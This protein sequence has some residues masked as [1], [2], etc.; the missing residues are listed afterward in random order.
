MALGIY[1]A[2]PR[3]AP[4]PCS[5]DTNTWAFQGALDAHHRRSD[6]ARC[7]VLG[8][9]RLLI[10]LSEGVHDGLDRHWGGCA[11]VG[12]HNQTEEFLADTFCSKG[13]RAFV[14][15]VKGI[16]VDDGPIS[17]LPCFRMG[18]AVSI[19]DIRVI[20]SAVECNAVASRLRDMIAP[21]LIHL[22]GIALA[23]AMHAIA[24]GREQLQFVLRRQHG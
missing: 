16:C 17:G 22:L 24:L 12:R 19:S 8:H 4:A 9:Q 10:N 3:A 2:K 1:Q 18:E 21:N 20:M 23:P 7:P 5:G 6:L 15:I 11:R 13:R 14:A